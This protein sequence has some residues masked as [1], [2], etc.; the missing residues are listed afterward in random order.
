M[1]TPRSLMEGETVRR[2]PLIRY[3]GSGFRSKFKIRFA[4]ID[5]HNATCKPVKNFFQAAFDLITNLKKIIH[6]G[7]VINLDNY[8]GSWCY[9]K[10]TVDILELGC[11]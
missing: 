4:I 3:G 11:I 8:C 5:R 1:I 2:F 9:C 10:V 7:F 6:F